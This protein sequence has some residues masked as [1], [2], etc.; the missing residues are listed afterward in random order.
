MHAHM[1]KPVVSAIGRTM[2]AISLS[3]AVVACSSSPSPDSSSNERDHGADDS[4]TALNKQSYP[5][6]FAA[7]GSG[8]DECLF[9]VGPNP[10]IT[11]LEAQLG[12]APKTLQLP[13]GSI[14]PF[15]Y[16]AVFRQ[17]LPGSTNEPP[18]ALFNRMPPDGAE[19]ATRTECELTLIAD[20]AISANTIGD[21]TLAISAKNFESLR[22]HPSARLVSI[23]GLCAALG[24]IMFDT[25]D[26]FFDI[27]ETQMG[28]D[29]RISELSKE[30]YLGACPE[31]VS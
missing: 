14:E 21:D 8:D 1:Y 17:G 4:A 22:F 12:A 11:E 16:L 20:E 31:F 5:P 28:G 3:L 24:P 13:D 23:L 7:I 27:M 25:G 29:E 9:Y 2:V 19:R 10:T 30:H 26:R 18:I 6:G 15:D